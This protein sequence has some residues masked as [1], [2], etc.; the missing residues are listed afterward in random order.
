[1]P[2]RITESSFNPEFARVVEV[3][4]LPE[5]SDFP[6]DLAPSPEEAR[7]LARLMGSQAVRKVRFSGVLRPQ[8]GGWVLEGR[9]GATVVQTC[10]VTLDPVTTRLDLDIRRVFLPAARPEGGEVAIEPFDDDEA[11]VLGD[12]ID[13]GLVA[14]EAMALA[15]PPYPR[16]EGAELGPSSFTAP[17][18]EPLQDA[19]VRPFSALAA[20]R[21]KFN[22]TG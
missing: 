10:V 5:R 9:L 12:R 20:L 15:L 6:F 22:R 11:E 21:D 3:A 2:N 8:H 7:A 16:R 17:G 4:D 18:R 14:I 1:M 19:D 13:V